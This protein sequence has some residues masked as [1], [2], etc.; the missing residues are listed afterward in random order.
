M[1]FVLF[2]LLIVAIL[3]IMDKIRPD[4][5]A[6]S[7]MIILILFGILD[8][9]EA[10][11]SFS[12]PTVVMIAALFVVSEGLSQAGITSY[13]GNKISTFLKQGEANKLT[14]L[15]LSTIGIVGSF[16]SS[17]GIVA[18][19]VPIVQR[20]SKNTNIP[21]KK[22]F[23]PVAYAGLIS[24]MMTLIATAPN[25]IVSEE[26]EAQGFDSFAMLSFTPI[27]IGVLIT[28]I[29]YFWVINSFKTDENLTEDVDG[30]KPFQK[31]LDKYNLH[32]H[33]FRFKVDSGSLTE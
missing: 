11:N 20:I 19:F 31:L 27:G 29:I 22:V 28:A 9:G 14:T 23:I 17:T 12:N 33:V 18:L 10:L 2:L 26:L 5:I 8:V 24:G 4:L 32:L 30:D 3:F 13:L 6:L 7:A 16:M 1:Y 21:A 15:L 25:L